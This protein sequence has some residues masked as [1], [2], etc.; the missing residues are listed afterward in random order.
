[1]LTNWIYRNLHVQCEDGT[2]LRSTNDPLNAILKMMDVHLQEL[3]RRTDNHSIEKESYV[4][5]R[6]NE[7]SS[8]VVYVNPEYKNNPYLY[9][10]DPIKREIS[11][12]IAYDDLLGLTSDPSV[13]DY[14]VKRCGDITRLDMSRY[15]KSNEVDEMRRLS[16][17]YDEARKNN[18]G[19][20]GGDTPENYFEDYEDYDEDGPSRDDDGPG[21]GD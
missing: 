5:I 21:L 16:K 1:M 3:S 14:F 4:F 19:N 18:Q 15:F 9:R 2:N 7:W 10:H 11:E 8:L 12:E 20:T 13:E 6:L 17:A